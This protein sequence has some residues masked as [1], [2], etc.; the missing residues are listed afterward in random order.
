MDTGKSPLAMLAKTCET[1][2]LPDTPNKKDKKDDSKKSTDTSPASLTTKK[3]RSSPKSAKSVSEP[4]STTFPGLPKPHQMANGFPTA[5]PFYNPLMTYSMPPFATFPTPF[6][7][8][9]PCPAALMQRPCVT[10]GCP[11]CTPMPPEM[12]A[13][14]AAHPLFST[15]ANMMPSASSAAA[16]SSYQ[17]LLAQSMIPSTSTSTTFPLSL[18][19]AFPTSLPST[20]TPTT[21]NA[22]PRATPKTSP[23]TRQHICNWMV[24]SGVCG[25]KFDNETEL[26]S[27]VKAVHTPSPP[28]SAT[29][30]TPERAVKTP[31]G[32]IRPSQTPTMSLPST[33]AVSLTPTGSLPMFNRFHPYAKPVTS[34]HL[35]VAS[36]VGLLPSG[37]PN[38]AAAAAMFQ[39]PN[40]L[41]AMYTQRLMSTMPMP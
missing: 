1:I 33:S 12:M 8:R 15:Y 3:D 10:P 16:L 22:T 28:S 36:G 21:S 35:P 9:M 11:S 18:P 5:F 19:S 4:L 24:S 29:S 40:A 37:I 27:H 17:A 26:T 41:Q 20:S 14:F 30:E 13:S 25:K 39:F 38:P 7:P 23:Q 32:P 6:M 2:G 31:I 34:T